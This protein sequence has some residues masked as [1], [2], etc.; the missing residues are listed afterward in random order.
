MVGRQGLGTCVQ[1]CMDAWTLGGQTGLRMAWYTVGGPD[2][3]ICTLMGM[4]G[5]YCSGEG[6]WRSEREDC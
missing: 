1:S 3:R 5:M 4:G 2:L 6:V